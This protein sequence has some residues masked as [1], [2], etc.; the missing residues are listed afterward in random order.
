MRMRH[1]GACE[2]VR[3]SAV[4]LKFQDFAFALCHRLDP[5][6]R[7]TDLSSVSESVP[8][9]RQAL[10]AGWV[11]VARS[12]PR[13]LK[14]QPSPVR[15]GALP[16]CLPPGLS[17]SLKFISKQRAAYCASGDKP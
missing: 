16:A 7:G 1:V 17:V 15:P 8:G 5:F 4:P 3:F 12:S 2:G 6:L 14:E 13:G 9:C 10:E 11:A